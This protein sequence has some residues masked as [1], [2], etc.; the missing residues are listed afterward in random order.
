MFSISLPKKTY[1]HIY[2]NV[3]LHFY[4]NVC[5][6][7][8]K[9]VYKLQLWKCYKNITVY[10]TYK[11]E[12]Y[13]HRKPK[14]STIIQLV[15]FLIHCQISF[16]LMALMM[17]KRNERRRRTKGRSPKRNVSNIHIDYQYFIYI[18]TTKY[19]HLLNYAVLNWT[20]TPI[21]SKNDHFMD[22]CTP[23]S[24]E[25]KEEPEKEVQEE[26]EKVQLLI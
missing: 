4:E 25:K 22:S 23:H 5:S 19:I 7:F 17:R 1:L 26:E 14:K 24:K 9:S 3:Y 18:N 20:I 11:F 6:Y 10:C 8:I 2:S 16:K 21:L 12:L 15:L 13:L